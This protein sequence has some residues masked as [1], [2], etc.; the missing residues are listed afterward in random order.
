VGATASCP[1]G[2]ESLAA[3]YCRKGQVDYIRVLY[4]RLCQGMTIAQTAESL[5]ISP[6][7]VDHYFRHARDKLA[8]SLGTLVRR[9]VQC[10]CSSNDSRQEF[11]AEWQRLG[12]YLV[13]HGGL[14]EAVRR[15]CELRDPVQ[16]KTQKEVGVAQAVTR[17]TSVI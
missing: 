5:K 12:G 14:E 16:A 15:A 4:S 1:L 13:D 8:E 11:T 17:L 9:H 3:D 6:T 10:Y 2:I 7:A